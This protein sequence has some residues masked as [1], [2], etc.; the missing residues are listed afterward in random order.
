M[1]KKLKYISLVVIINIILL[2]LIS[3][4]GFSPLDLHKHSQIYNICEISGSKTKIFLDS[5]VS[6]KI[7]EYEYCKYKILIFKDSA[8]ILM[9][10]GGMN[11][12][13][14][15][16]WYTDE[17]YLYPVENIEITEYKNVL[18]HN[19]IVISYLDGA[20]SRPII[21][22]TCE[23]DN[24]SPLVIC[25]KSNYEIDING[26]KIN[27]LISCYN[28]RADIIYLY[29]NKLYIAEIGDILNKELNI[30]GLMGYYN[31]ENNKFE[32]NE[33]QN[34][35]KKVSIECFIKNNILYYKLNQ[36]EK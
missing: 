31:A 35:E 18:G 10:A 17:P 6:E 13:S 7:V 32:F 12:I 9:F 1:K 26:D 21:Y 2:L 15:I 20:D 16:F 3:C 36:P 14:E 8:E 19:G 34:T 33:N 22:F 24:I 25:N 27:D 4:S 23:N 5:T 28:Y 11:S 29:D 30:N